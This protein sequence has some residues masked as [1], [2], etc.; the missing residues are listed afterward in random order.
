[1]ETI[2]RTFII[3]SGPN[4]FVQE[5]VFNIAPIKRVAIAMNTNSAFTGQFQ[6]HYQNFDLRE[7]RNVYGGRAI[8]SLDTTN[9]CRAYV[10]TM[11]AM[12]FN[13]Q[14]PALPN[15]QFQNHYTLV[16]DLTSLQDAGIRCLI[17]L[18]ENMSTI[19][20]DQFG[21]VAKNV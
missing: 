19:K 6:V 14:F 8:V 4:Q 12:K 21:T 13:E 11:K 9:Y 1:M 15:H 17:V 10:K 20:I 5:N 2:A 16:F 7:L 3:A 18:G